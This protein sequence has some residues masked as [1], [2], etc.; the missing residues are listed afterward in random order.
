MDCG[1]E[2]LKQKDI[3]KEYVDKASD[4]VQME[5]STVKADARDEEHKYVNA[6]KTAGQLEVIQSKAD[7][8]SLLPSQRETTV[9]TAK[10]QSSQLSLQCY[11]C[12]IT[13]SD[14]K[15]KERHMKKRHPAEY[16][17]YML[18]DS[19][20]ICYVCDRAFGSSRELM[21]HQR[22]HTEKHPFK[23]PV[24]GDSFG[25]SS[26]LTVHKRSHFGQLGYACTDCGKLCKTLT[27]LKYHRRVHTGERPYQCGKC[28]K[29]FSQSSGLHRHEVTH[30]E[31]ES[32]GQCCA[33]DM[34]DANANGSQSESL[35]CSKCLITF[36]DVKTSERHMRHKHFK[37]YKEHIQLDTVHTCYACENSLPSSPQL[38]DHQYTP[39][40]GKLSVTGQEKHSY[41]THS[42]SNSE[43]VVQEGIEK[44][45]GA[46]GKE[47]YGT[48]RIQG[49]TL[50]GDHGKSENTHFCQQCQMIFKD[51][52]SKQ[53]HVR[54]KHT[55]PDKQAS[56]GQT[57]RP[58]KRKNPSSGTPGRPTR[59][60]F[61]CKICDDQFSNQAMMHEH[62]NRFHNTVTAKVTTSEELETDLVQL[63][64]KE[65]D[66]LLDQEPS[67]LVN[68]KRVPELQLLS[69]S[70]SSQEYPLKHSLE[71]TDEW[72]PSVHALEEHPRTSQ[73]PVT[74]QVAEDFQE[75]DTPANKIAEEAHTQSREGEE[76]A[77]IDTE[78]MWVSSSKADVAD[79]DVSNDQHLEMDL[80][81]TSSIPQQC[82]H[83]DSEEALQAHTK[84]PV[85]GL[86]SLLAENEKQLSAKQKQICT[87]LQKSDNDEQ[88]HQPSSMIKQEDCVE[89]G[90]FLSR[91]DLQEQQKSFS[92]NVAP[93]QQES[94]P[95]SHFH[96][97]EEIHKLPD[98]ER[99]LGPVK[100]EL[101]PLF[102]PEIPV[103][104]DSTTA[105]Q[106]SNSGN[107]VT[108]IL[109]ALDMRI[110]KQERSLQQ[111]P[112]VDFERER[113]W[114]DSHNQH[115]S[116][117]ESGHSAAQDAELIWI[118]QE[119]CSVLD[120]HRDA[121]VQS[122]RRF[123][124]EEDGRIVGGMSSQVKDEQ[125][126]TEPLS[127][128]SKQGALNTFCSLNTDLQA[129]KGNVRRGDVDRNLEV[130]QGILIERVKQEEP[131]VDLQ[132][133]RTNMS[134]AGEVLHRGGH[135][136]ME[137][138]TDASRWEIEQESAN[139]TDLVLQEDNRVNP[140]YN[141]V[142]VDMSYLCGQC[143]I[144]FRDLRTKERHMH[145]RCHLQPPRGDADSGADSDPGVAS[146]SDHD[147]ATLMC[148]QCGDS[149]PVAAGFPQG[150]QLSPGHT[151]P[152]RGFQLS[153]GACS[154]D[155]PG[156]CQSPMEV[157]Q[158]MELTGE[159]SALGEEGRIL[160][161][162]NARD[163]LIE[164]EDDDAAQQEPEFDVHMW[165][166]KKRL[167]LN[168]SEKFLDLIA[169]SSHS[170]VSD[171]PSSDFEDEE[172]IFAAYHTNDLLC[173][174]GEEEEEEEEEEDTG[175]KD[176]LGH[177]Y[178]KRQLQ[179]GRIQLWK[180][181]NFQPLESLLFGEDPDSYC[182]QEAPLEP[183]QYF[184]KYLDR[185]MW[186][187][188]A[189]GTN[190]NILSSNESTT[191][192]EV[193]VL[194]G[195]FIA[196]GTLKFPS[197]KLYWNEST[198]VPI[199]ANAMSFQR[200][201]ELENALQVT[202]KQAEG[203]QANRLSSVQPVLERLR[204][205]C[206]HL[207]RE[208]HSTIYLRT[209]PIS[210][211]VRCRKQAMEKT[212]G[213]DSV[214]LIGASG[215][216]LDFEVCPTQTSGELSLADSVVMRLVE[217]I[218]RTE[219]FLIFLDDNFTSIE[220]MD[221]LCLEGIHTAGRVEMDSTT[222]ISQDSR[223]EVVRHDGKIAMVKWQKAC[224]LSTYVAG[225]PM[226][227]VHQ[228]DKSRRQCVILPQPCV[229]HEWETFTKSV[230]LNDS[231]INLYRIPARRR[232]WTSQLLLHF[233]DLVVVN[234][235][236]EYCRDCKASKIKPDLS[237]LAFRMCISECLITCRNKKKEPANPTDETLCDQEGGS[238][239]QPLP[240]LALRYDG[241]DH[242]PEQLDQSEASF[243]RRQ[244]FQMNKLL[245]WN[246]LR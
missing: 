198:R 127:M 18:G 108:N 209:I 184:S 202:G 86:Q 128:M 185:S 8:P 19:L 91:P 43:A 41:T 179:E 23:C 160:E 172:A 188:I 53:R 65:D 167:R 37:E 245:S 5:T 137:E 117:T 102:S 116:N 180:R 144:V 240:E 221:R 78:R 136:T 12:H 231:L 104:A 236:L 112:D 153:V 170:E 203:T 229:A 213:L 57:G 121:E 157:D 233:I 33:K 126:S 124:R 67:L 211:F 133:G 215:M 66:L 98:K 82:T 73:S 6:Q 235:W 115:N 111:S 122:D 223:E 163:E 130:V 142:A 101:E 193:A 1:T 38:T 87:A 71:G 30:T 200:F 189:Q 151:W 88:E 158:A 84:S 15:S 183:F 156:N 120:T 85:R 24:C 3:E 187:L 155:Q 93:M 150:Q 107:N 74:K 197:V 99:Q 181:E 42:P 146:G 242:W 27:L 105:G 45:V 217:T 114:A 72:E 190:Q 243:C 131:D 58:S 149:F 2:N 218:P 103:E 165:V 214:L 176:P 60:L 4:K 140:E 225:E 46:E 210:G 234:A 68:E 50:Q 148:Q 220:L 92:E 70:P 227:K 192:E 61:S 52:K 199:I 20:F 239:M 29:R 168:H 113:P 25:R 90:N 106:D 48:D 40:E 14:F 31:E 237:L 109:E 173:E 178:V 222:E 219:S 89:L 204:Q 166:Y 119:N 143:H 159:S 76:V 212:H 196:M 129:T 81:F 241:R 238:N 54:H 9:P 26:E 141:A 132:D 10:P 11:E 205:T 94:L 195:M 44:T 207:P 152:Q 186:E 194:I 62:Q 69:L 145:H 79:G 154:H 226:C 97:P 182:I 59:R 175:S 191:P 55:L 21:A 51:L 32:Q 110:V 49:L 162:V 244:S 206:R 230:G 64:Q 75:L 177:T 224:F 216:V 13:F 134:P 96:S 161:K 77:E 135:L 169:Q 201:V 47:E 34:E 63:R 83:E 35:Q 95:Q 171:L 164:N 28:G 7:P 246:W 39:E 22:G 36:N 17:E 100:E 118:K 123:H 208:K 174:P 16:E 139:P 80:Y 125:M 56:S 228:W 232:K 147:G 138:E